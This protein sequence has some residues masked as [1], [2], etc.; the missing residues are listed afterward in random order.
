VRRAYKLD[1]H[2]RKRRRFDGRR[3]FSQSLTFHRKRFDRSANAEAP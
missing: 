2:E 3:G 1:N